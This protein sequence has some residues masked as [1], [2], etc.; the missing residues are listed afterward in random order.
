MNDS[1][2]ILNRSCVAEGGF[3]EDTCSA[4]ARCQEKR[5]QWPAIRVQGHW[6]HG[7]DWYLTGGRIRQVRC[8]HATSRLTRGLR[9]ARRLSGRHF[10]NERKVQLMSWQCLPRKYQCPPPG[11]LTW[12]RRDRPLSRWVM[13]VRFPGRSAP[14][15]ARGCTCPAGIELCAAAIIYPRSPVDQL[16]RTSEIT[17][18]G[19]DGDN[20]NPR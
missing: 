20:R 4:A 18:V 17:R 12:G 13:W 15:P 1:Q 8:M 14:C 3:D 10:S 9:T 19:S 7:G 2:L 6:R 11:G 5:G 16:S